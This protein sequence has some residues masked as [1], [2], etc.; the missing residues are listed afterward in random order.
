M[1]SNKAGTGSLQIGASFSI[2]ERKNYGYKKTC[3]I[4]HRSGPAAGGHCPGGGVSEHPSGIFHW[5]WWR[6]Y[7]ESLYENLDFISLCLLLWEKFTP[8]DHQKGIT[9]DLKCL[10]LTAL[11][12][13][14]YIALLDTLGF[15]L[16]SILYMAAQMLIF[17]PL[18]NR[19][20]KH[21]IMI[22]VLA[23]VV[24]LLINEVFEEVFSL[25][26]PAGILF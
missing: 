20:R 9:A 25:L 18:E 5:H 21:Y 17:I 6:L 14:L 16:S 8:D 10:G 15:V 3:G 22:G 11:A 19:N 13:F 26:L 23:L 4:H 2:C 12:L 24:P 7:A 1:K